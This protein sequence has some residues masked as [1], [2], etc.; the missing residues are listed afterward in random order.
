MVKHVKQTTPHLPVLARAHDRGHLYELKE[1]G[2][3]Q[4][5][6][7]TY[8]SALHLGGEALKRLGLHPFRVEQ[9]KTTFDAMENNIQRSMYQDWMGQEGVHRH[10]SYYR[11]LFLELEESLRKALQQDRADKHAHGERG[12]IPPPKGY[13][14]ALAETGENTDAQ[15]T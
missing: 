7:E 2:A 5:I 10:L 11:K 12:W 14:R 15:A 1:A 4:I 3:D 6:K 13:D 8:H 9:Q